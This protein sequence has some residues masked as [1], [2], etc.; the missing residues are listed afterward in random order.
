MSVSLPTYG[1]LTHRWGWLVALAGSQQ[2]GRRQ[3]ERNTWVHGG[4]LGQR[5]GLGSA[6]HI[7]KAQPANVVC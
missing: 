2:Q 6:D 3:Q 1:Q 7:I 5:A 4:L